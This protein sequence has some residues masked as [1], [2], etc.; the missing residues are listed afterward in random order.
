MQAAV[1][2]VN[3]AGL[4]LWL[5]LQILLITRLLR[6]DWRRYPLLFVLVV[7]EVRMGVADAPRVLA[8]Y[9]QVPDALRLRTG[10]Y[11]VI[12]L[13]DQVLLFAV[14]LSL[15]NRAAAYLQSRHLIRAACVLGA[16]LFGAVT[17]LIHHDPNSPL[18]M[19]WVT[20][21]TRDLN[22]CTTILDLALWFLLLG[23]REKDRRLF[24]LSGGLGIEFS[25]SAIGDSLLSMAGPKKIYWLALS[26]GI[27]LLAA[28]L[29]RIYIWARAFRPAVPPRVKQ[30][31]P[32]QV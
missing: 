32:A 4:I 5:P 12:D 7:V 3:L 6:G 14:V 28:N 11:V 29:V 9:Q 18:V 8:V 30:P 13:V 25:G 27:I 21:W 22:V 16:L 2:A 17:Y 31:A 10:T 20:P 1:N 19:A 23:R 26:G 15:I 24:L